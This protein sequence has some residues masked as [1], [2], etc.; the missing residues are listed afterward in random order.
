MAIGHGTPTL[1]QKHVDNYM[2]VEK[3][4]IVAK[5][6]SKS[7]PLCSFE[8]MHIEHDIA[9]YFT[10]LCLVTYLCVWVLGE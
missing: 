2:L 4:A 3:Y 7:V 6:I 8:C 5:I 9:L 1:Y 10:Q